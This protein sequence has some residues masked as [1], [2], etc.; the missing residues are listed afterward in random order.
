VGNIVGSIVVYGWLMCVYV[1]IAWR[2]WVRR[3]AKFSNAKWR[4]GITTLGFG[5]STVSLVVI[6]A[7]AVHALITGGLPHYHP[8]LLF[9]IG[10]GLL[11]A[12]C[13]IVAAIVGAGQLEVPTI[14][15]SI[16]FS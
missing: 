3:D 9:A 4:S 13:G 1:A 8:V 16:L 2:R 5:A 11:S 12:L 7:L 14:A 15:C 10:L 6:V